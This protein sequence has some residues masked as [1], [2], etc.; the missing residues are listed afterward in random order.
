MVDV[1]I[2]LGSNLADP[3]AQIS[4]ALRSIS[5]FKDS[6]LY[7]CSSLYVSKPMGP[8]DQPDY[9]N[10]VL[11]LHSTFPALRLLSMLQK[12]EQQHGRERKNNRWGPRTLDLDILLYGQEFID[13]AHLVVPHYG[14]KQREFVLY[15]LHEIA[16]DLRLP[17]G[18]QLEELLG[19]C[20]INGLQKISNPPQI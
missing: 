18:T 16:P 10:A 2:G 5:E 7:S 15:P 4:Q 20:D 14:M 17:C 3:A 1:Y 19:Q 11:C 13:L 6:H 8:Q 9:V 12:V